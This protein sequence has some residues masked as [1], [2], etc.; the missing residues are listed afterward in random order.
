MR[1]LLATI[2]GLVAV[3]ALLDVVVGEP[4]QAPPAAAPDPDRRFASRPDLTPP[5]FTVEGRTRDFVFVSPK[6]R[7]GQA[8]P[9]IL[10]ARGE[11]VW[12][13]P[14]AKGVVADD[15]RVQTYRGQPVL[16][17][18]EGKTN[19]RGYGQGTWVIADASYREIARVKA[20]GPVGGDLHDIELTDEGTALI[21]VYEIVPA[22]LT[23]IGAYADGEA[24]DSVIQEIDLETG[25]LVWE[26]SSLEHVGLTESLAGIPQKTRFPYDYFHINSIDVDADGNLL[27]SARN[28]WAIYKLDRKT[29]EVIWRLGGYRSDFALGEGVR[30]AWQHDARRRADGTLTLFDNQATPKVGPRSRALTLRL[31]E[32]TMRATAAKIVEHPDGILSI[33]QG[34]SQLLDDGHTFVGFGSG[35]RVSEFDAGGRLRFDIRFPDAVDSYR[36]YRFAW[37]G[38]PSEPPRAAARRVDDAVQVAASWNGATAVTDWEV[39]AGPSPDALQPAGKAH[40]RGFETTIPVRTEAAYVA[41]RALAGTRELAVSEPAKVEP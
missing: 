38:E 26:W 2:V 8:G 31:D 29:G 12:F 36:G 37:R 21:P 35:R 15:F 20:V 27:V 30:F 7:N 10:D 9:A 25:E 24:V 18:W 11:Y 1:T 23:P 14:M 40:R 32:D 19:P 22:D 13:K 34:N 6:R 16:T 33:A 4:S 28:T 17:W 5:A 3:L 39:L 41:V